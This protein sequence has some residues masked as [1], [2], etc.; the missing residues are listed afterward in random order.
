MD[1]VDTALTTAAP[2]KVACNKLA[3]ACGMAFFAYSVSHG[4]CTC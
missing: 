2:T 4:C 3:G 1:V